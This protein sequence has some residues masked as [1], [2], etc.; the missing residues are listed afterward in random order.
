MSTEIRRTYIGG[1]P[2]KR[3][4]GHWKPGEPVHCHAQVLAVVTRDK[5][6]LSMNGTAVLTLSELRQLVRDIEAEAS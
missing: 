5:V 4:Q 1:H 3:N 6:A 2:V